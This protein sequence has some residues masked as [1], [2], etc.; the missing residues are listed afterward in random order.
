[1]GEAKTPYRRWNVVS[2]DEMIK[3]IFLLR[4][5]GNDT[6]LIWVNLSHKYLV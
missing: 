3:D 4:E 5:I 6:F 2:D 1:M